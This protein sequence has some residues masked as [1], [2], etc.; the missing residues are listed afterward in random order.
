MKS[1][2]DT[3][4]LIVGFTSSFAILVIVVA[5]M[6]MNLIVIERVFNEQVQICQSKAHDILFDDNC[7]V[8]PSCDHFNDIR[9]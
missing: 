3:S 4:N 9:S 8:R 1:V 5:E 2:H 6:H 7:Y